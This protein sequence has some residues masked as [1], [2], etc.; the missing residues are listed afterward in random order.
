MYGD[1]LP[2]LSGSPVG[3]EPMR[4]MRL[5]SNARNSTGTL[6]KVTSDC[7][8]ISREKIRPYFLIDQVRPRFLAPP[9]VGFNP[10]LRMRS[11]GTPPRFLHRVFNNSVI[12]FDI[13]ISPVCKNRYRSF[14]TRDR[15]PNSSVR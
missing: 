6:I 13:F 2:D 12:F 15:I 10:C 3:H 5:H 4:G 11:G 1:L 8:S 9:P 7:A 14:P